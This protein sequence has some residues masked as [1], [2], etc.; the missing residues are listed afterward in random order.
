MTEAIIALHEVSF[1]RRKRLILD[2]LSLEIQAGEMIAVMGPSGTGKTTLMRLL[3]GQ[4]Q[5][6]SG[7]VWVL[8]KNL[9][10][11]SRAELMA[12]RRRMSM[13]FQSNAL[14]SDLTLGENVAFPLREVLHLP[15]ELIDILVEMKLQA[16][17]LGGAQQLM[18]AQL[19]GG[20]ARRAALARAMAMDPE[21]MIYDEPFTGQD[22]ITLGILTTLLRNFHR[23]LGMTSLI[24]SHDVAEVSQIVDKIL[25]LSGGNLLAFAP[26]AELFA[27][28]NPLIAQFMHAQA[29]GPIPFH[30]PAGSDYASRLLGRAGA[31]DA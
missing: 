25:L 4:L 23:A 21:L 7:E 26:P 29:D 17:G 3:T 24:V 9:A 22:P 14:F 15:P 27:S 11:L 12:L 2:R 19:S 5:P 18:P 16:V 6:D 13:L 8:G 20:M 31:A 1:R 30:Y 28:D 10:T